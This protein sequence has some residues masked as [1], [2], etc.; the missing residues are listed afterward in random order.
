LGLRRFTPRIDEVRAQLE[1]V[2]RPGGGTQKLCRLAVRVKR[3]GSF[4]VETI[5]DDGDVAVSRAAERAVHRMHRLL[6]RQREERSTR[7]REEVRA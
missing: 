1:E 3:L 7:V 4:A 2:Q 5:E 6:D